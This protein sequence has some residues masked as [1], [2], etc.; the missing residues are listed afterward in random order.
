MASDI[1]SFL[2]SF[3]GGGARN[4]RYEVMIGFPTFLGITQPAIQQKISFT[5]KASSIP[6]SELG[7]AIVPYKGR[8]IKVPGDRSFGDWNVT[9]IVD[10]DFKGRDVFEQWSAGMLGNT[11]NVTKSPNEL[12]PL[13]IYGQA[14]VNVL[15]RYDKIIKRYQITGMFPKTVNEITLGYD[16]DNQVMEQSVTFAINEWVGYDAKGKLITN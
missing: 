11:S 1:N 4:N 15:D 8:S 12:N 16:Q 7:E 5:C 3:T 14:Q 6:A 10:N 13:K 2:S 9:I